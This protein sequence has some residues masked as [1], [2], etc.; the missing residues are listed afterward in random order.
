M[1]LDTIRFITYT[2]DIGDE[3]YFDT[4][5]SLALRMQNIV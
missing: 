3:F 5:I 4:I 2:N 1:Q